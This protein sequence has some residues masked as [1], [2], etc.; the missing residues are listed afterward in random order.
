MKTLEKLSDEQLIALFASG[1]NEAFEE[2]LYKYK[3]RLYRYIFGITKQEKLTED[4]FQDTFIKAIMIIKQGRYVDMGHFYTWICRIAHNLVIDYYRKDVQ[5]TY[6][7]DEA[8][9]DLFRDAALREG[10]VQDCI[11]LNETHAEV[12][13]VMNNL[14]DEQ[15]RIVKLRYFQELSFKE[16]AKIENISINTALGRMRYAILNMRKEMRKLEYP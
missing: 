7:N 9:F 3:D 8:G 11:I 1:C 12:T 4:M 14:P 5:N 2:L 13:E 15:Q 6:S 10:N 16:I